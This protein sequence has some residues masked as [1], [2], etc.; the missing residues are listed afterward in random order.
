M[1]TYY[2]GIRDELLTAIKKSPLSSLC[3]ISEE[4]AGLHF[5]M[6]VTTD[7]TDETLIENAQKNGLRISCLSQYY[8]DQTLC[9]PEHILVLNYSTLSKKNIEHAVELLHKV[10]FL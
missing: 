8:Y 2:R 6:Q 4:D 10:L 1:R 7:L 9:P 5:L 3:K